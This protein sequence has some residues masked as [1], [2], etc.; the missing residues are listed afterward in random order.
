MRPVEAQTCS[1]QTDANKNML[2]TEGLQTTRGSRTKSSCVRSQGLH[3]F[4]GLENRVNVAN[5][6]NWTVTEISSF[7]FATQSFCKFNFFPHNQFLWLCRI[8]KSY[9][10]AEMQLFFQIQCVFISRL[11]MPHMERNLLQYYCKRLFQNKVQPP[12]RREP[13]PS[14]KTV[15]FLTI[16]RKLVKMT[17]Y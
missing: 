1:K 10:P 9:L 4:R 6:Q 15:C 14:C 12:K 3:P 11:L 7:I 17:E 16:T 5:S 8:I 2:E 13:E